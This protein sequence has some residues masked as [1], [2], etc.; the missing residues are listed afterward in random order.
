MGRPTDRPVLPTQRSKKARVYVWKRNVAVPSPAMSTAFRFDLPPR[1]LG[2]RRHL[3]ACLL[4]L[5]LAALVGLLAAI[6]TTVGS[7]DDDFVARE[8]V[9]D[10]RDLPTGWVPVE[11]AYYPYMTSSPLLTLLLEDE[12]VAG[13]FSAYRDPQDSSAVATYV[14][15]RP[16]EPL[17]LPAGP[18]SGTL[19]RV[20]PLVMELE[21]LA[22]QRL[23]G[24][25][26]EV[27]FAATD[28]PA[29]GALRGRTLAPPTGEGVQSDFVLFTAGPVL[30][31]VVVEHPDGE[32]PFQ[33]VEELAQLVYGRIQRQLD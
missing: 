12:T 6:L 28:T 2:P 7:E 18:D 15:F 11:A 14:V 23:D 21:R 33:P 31:L 16:H 4:A 1:R 29:A 22:R 25:L 27:F 26:P 32:E 8:T 17:L 10:Q 9:L 5:E 30:A 3:L 24:A 13:A 20:A 19:K